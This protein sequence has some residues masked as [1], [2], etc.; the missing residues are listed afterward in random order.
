MNLSVFK[1]SGLVAKTPHLQCRGPGSFPGQGTRSHM[2]QVKN[3][4]AATKIKDLI[5]VST[6]ETALCF[7][8][9]R[10]IIDVY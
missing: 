3:P 4:L 10:C 8:Y 7:T 6:R 9:S 2:L 5:Y 1:I